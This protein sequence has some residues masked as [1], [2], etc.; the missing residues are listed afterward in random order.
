MDAAVP[1][2]AGADGIGGRIESSERT[3]EVDW[4]GVHS[5]GSGVSGVR[6]TA[7]RAGTNAGRQRY[8]PGGAAHHQTNSRPEPIDQDLSAA[9]YDILEATLNPKPKTLDPKH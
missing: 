3:G 9:D 4:Q 6:G 8:N 5:D 7:V 2:H 1:R